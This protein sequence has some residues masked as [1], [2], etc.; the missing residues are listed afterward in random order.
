MDYLVAYWLDPQSSEER[1]AALRVYFD[2]QLYTKSLFGGNQLIVTNID[3]QGAIP[4]DE[5]K[6]FTREHA[7]H[8]KY[9][10]LQQILR[11]GHDLPIC[12]HDHDMFIKSPLTV[13]AEAIRCTSKNRE[14]FSD[15]LLVFPPLA[16]E[17]LENFLQRLNDLDC[18]FGMHVGYGT[19]Q[20][21]E[22]IYSSEFTLANLQPYPFADI[23]IEADIIS[24]DLVS[25]DIREHHSL[26]AVNCDAKPIPAK[27]QAVHGHLNKG[28]ATELLVDWIV[29]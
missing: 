4:F 21:H 1:E 20:R 5:P 7:M 11:A 10:A 14:R 13:N 19:E 2:M 23:P 8:V 12:L 24:R 16:R 29:S 17:P 22:G 9:F 26:D 18:L 25:F 27:A 3:Y 28:P 15:Q 6:G